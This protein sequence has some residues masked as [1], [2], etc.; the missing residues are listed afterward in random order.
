MNRPLT[1][2]RLLAALTLWACCTPLH[3]ETSSRLSSVFLSRGEQGTLEVAVA[4]G[5]PDRLPLT[6]E[7]DGVDIEPLGRGPR[8]SMLPGRRREYV[9]SFGI[10]SYQV[11]K[12]VI[13]AIEV[14]VDGQ[15]TT[16]EPLTF[17]VFNPD[18]LKWSEL[19]L[20]GETIRYATCFRALNGKPFEN[21]TTPAEIKVFVPAELE[22]QDWGIPEFQRDGVTAW[23]FQPSN[24]RSRVNLLGIPY[25][26]VSY[27]STLT[28]TRTG[29]VSIGPARVRL[30]TSAV[31]MDP[32][33][34][35]VN[36]EIYLDVPQLEMDVK[37]LPA[38]PIAG[39]ENA[40]GK[41][42][43]TATA[44]ITDVKEG[45]PISVDLT[46]TGSG[47]LDTLRPP[48]LA[49]D[50]GWKVY[51]TTTE[52]RGDE[53]RQLAGTVVF[54]Q[55][56]RPLEMKTEIP[57]FQLVYFD[58]TSQTYQTLSTPAIPLQMTRGVA[59]AKDPAA[60][61]AQALPIPFERMTDILT[62][63]RTAQLTAPAGFQFHPWMGHLVAGLAALALAA[64]AL[65][66]RYGHRLR[67][68]PLREIQ[69]R[70]IREISNTPV[71][72]D[73]SFLRAAGRFIERRLSGKS[74]GISPEIQAIL[75]ERDQN[76]F[77]SD[78]AK[79]SLPSDRRAQILKLLRQATLVLALLFTLAPHS[80]HA[81]DLSTQANEAYDS[82]RYDD[83][84][85][86]WLS[87]GSYQ[88]L[89]AS[90]L[91]NIGDA[92]YRSGSPGYASLYF[93]RALL[94]DSTLA[95]ARQNLRFIERKYGAVTFQRNDYQLVLSKLPLGAWQ[96]CYWGGLW[97]CL[98][99]LLAIL[100][101][102]VGQRLRLAG[103]VA[104]IVAPLMLAIGFLACHYFPDDSEFAPVARQ[105][106][107][108][109]E[110]AKLHTDA[111][112]T[113]PEV[114]DAPPGSLCEI[115]TESGKWSYIAFTNKTRG[116]IPT[117]ALER[118][119]PTQPPT[120]P[121]FKKPKADSKSA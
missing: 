68:D 8:T 93:R 14:M 49:D 94:R 19:Q 82:A 44:A 97:L 3:A 37:P 28:P 108:V 12:H 79:S 16:T 61:L 59:P 73:A 56:I 88:D 1:F 65:W 86:H 119:I 103:I 23:R 17:T 50:S 107:V 35:Q 38:S 72:D 120:L 87:A 116:W 89:S 33:P 121:D 22:V 105:A 27:P 111:A 6:P 69:H 13:P 57:P 26:A 113:S 117:A 55:S 29:K 77:R 95:E 85:E 42:R 4:G 36:P 7:V 63:L 58:P 83:A 78:L 74:T 39:F 20:N 10:G 80:A 62:P 81:A 47:N 100:A 66:M 112:R 45:D 96:A 2:R 75:A 40:V 106:V 34:R 101:S 46:L 76:C 64:K 11:G 52:Q 5:Q 98:I 99:A 18:D 115:I 43:L 102:R 41:F 71:G 60:A 84:I 32:F 21:E 24:Q 118:L 109:Q 48:K 104:L 92:S 51:S 110:K 114:I 53:R 67:K 9:F 54:H 31:V 30:V 15:K 90:T 70:E 91:Y 25:Y